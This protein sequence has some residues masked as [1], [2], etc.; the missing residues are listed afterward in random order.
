MRSQYV[1]AFILGMIILLLL[2]IVALVWINMNYLQPEQPLNDFFARWSGTR[3]FLLNGWSP[4]SEQTTAEVQQ[5]AYG[6]AARRGENPGLFVV[7]FF[8]IF[9]FAPFALVSDFHLANS[10][11]LVLLQISLFAA[12]GLSISLSEWRP[13]WWVLVLLV[14]LTFIWFHNL[15]ALNNANYSILAAL[16]RAIS[17]L[18]SK[19]P[20]D[21]QESYNFRQS[22]G[23]G[24]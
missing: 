9:I 5:M 6:R 8:S 17:R 21:S 19:Q 23:T 16:L 20:I 13:K 4:Y 24:R 7:P 10:L 22:E 12:L 2:F 3:L 15:R 11:W 18:W 1:P 14:L